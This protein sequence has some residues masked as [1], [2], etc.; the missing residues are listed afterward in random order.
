MLDTGEVVIDDDFTALSPVTGELRHYQSQWFPARD[1]DGAVFGVAVLVSDVTER[2]RAEVALRRSVERTEQLQQATA[3]L[4]EALTV[5][6]VRRVVAR[7]A[8]AATGA[9][10]AEVLMA[11]RRRAPAGRRT[12]SRDPGRRCPSWS[13]AGAIGVLVLD[14]DDQPAGGR[15]RRS[16]ARSPASARSRWSGPGS[17]S[18]SGRPP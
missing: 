6:D 10:T 14:Y 11:S 17:T 8:P 13:P 18:G 7:T 3:A 15:G 2:R 12:G 9:R 5:A 4:G 16:W 1:A